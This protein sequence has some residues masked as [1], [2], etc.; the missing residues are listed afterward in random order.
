MIVK[1][2]G[3][4]LKTADSADS[5][6][7]G[8]LVTNQPLLTEAKGS[9]CR[10]YCAGHSRTRV[11]LWSP[12]ASGPRHRKRGWEGRGSGT[13]GTLSSPGRGVK[14]KICLKGASCPPG[15][16][17]GVWRGKWGGGG[18]LISPAQP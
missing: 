5:V 2:G 6:F 9:F 12:W 10:S 13:G 4:T 18:D 1:S 11:T 7:V 3:A 15:S 17:T 8:H 16:E 14:G